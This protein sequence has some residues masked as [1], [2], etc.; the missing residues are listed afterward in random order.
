MQR[1]YLPKWGKEAFPEEAGEAG[2]KKSKQSGK[3]VP[4]GGAPQLNGYSKMLCSKIIIFVV[5]SNL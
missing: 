4:V 3:L 5:G 1:I 2:E